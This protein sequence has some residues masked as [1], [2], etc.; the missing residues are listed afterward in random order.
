MDLQDLEAA[1]NGSSEWPN[2]RSRRTM[3]WGPMALIA[4]YFGVSAVLF[5]VF[6]G[7]KCGA[8]LSALLVFVN[9]ALSTKQLRQKHNPLAPPDPL[10]PQKC[11]VNYLGD[12]ALTTLIVVELSLTLLCGR[13]SDELLI[14]S[15]SL[16]LSGHSL[17]LTLLS[18][19]AMTR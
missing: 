12:C 19:F 18:A 2:A 11:M 3:L 17:F 9:L 13:V 1:L 7:N 5:A 10:L 15:M 14:W 16:I 8:L 4:G 6:G